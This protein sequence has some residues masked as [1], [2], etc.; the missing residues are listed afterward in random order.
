[1]G[2]KQRKPVPPRQVDRAT[3]VVLY[4]EG[5]HAGAEW[6]GTLGEFLRANQIRGEEAVEIAA[7][8]HARGE[9]RGG[10][11]AAPQWRLV[12]ARRAAAEAYEREANADPRYLSTLDK[13][14]SALG[15]DY[16]REGTHYQLGSREVGRLL[17][18]LDQMTA[19][20]DRWMAASA[21]KGAAK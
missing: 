9:Y 11:G 3:L 19:D 13:E 1:M 18:A 10:G 4:G 16:R 14:L 8:L 15:I 17:H 7:A 12:H 2:L 21:R 20:R 5:P 6:D